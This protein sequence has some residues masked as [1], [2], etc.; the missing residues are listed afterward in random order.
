MPSENV[1][2]AIT[3]LEAS[4]HIAV[5]CYLR[6][7]VAEAIALLRAELEAE[8][9]SAEPEPM[10]TCPECGTNDLVLL[11]NYPPN[12]THYCTRHSWFTPPAPPPSAEEV[13][14]LQRHVSTLQSRK[15]ALRRQVR[16]LGETPDENF[17][18]G[19]VEPR[20]AEPQGEVV[21]L[22][23]DKRLRDDDGWFEVLYDITTQGNHDS[24]DYVR[25]RIIHRW[26]RPEPQPAAW[27]PV[28]KE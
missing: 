28:G 8:A 16:S 19:P 17:P 11:S 7:K 3:L 9:P 15:A 18:T 14:T 24:L 20:Q 5:D 27:V 10:P 25:A 21:T 1:K 4:G 22:A 13:R 12:G 6:D 23:R 26:Q 2:K